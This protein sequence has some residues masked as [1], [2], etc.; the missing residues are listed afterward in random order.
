[1]KLATSRGSG[2]SIHGAIGGALDELMNLLSQL[3]LGAAA[4]P[5]YDLLMDLESNACARRKRDWLDIDSG[6]CIGVQQH[7]A[8]TDSER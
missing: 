6:I 3:G 5:I 7:G 8:D 4:R 2:V 1:V